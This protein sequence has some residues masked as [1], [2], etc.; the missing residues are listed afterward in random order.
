VLGERKQ[1][2]VRGCTV[3]GVNDLDLPGETVFSALVQVRSRHKAAP[4]LVTSGASG[5]KV[6]F[7]SLQMAVAPGQTAVFYR[8]NTVMGAGMIRKVAGA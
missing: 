1:L 2:A 6:E 4:A 8:E 5:F 7:S 3:T